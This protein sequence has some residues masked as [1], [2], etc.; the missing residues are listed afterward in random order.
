MSTDQK[1]L[2][3]D[4]LKTVQYRS[5]WARLGPEVSGTTNKFLA[6]LID[7]PCLEHFRSMPSRLFDEHFH[8]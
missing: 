2:T 8:K 7:S 3:Y 4:S 5:T 1:T 6:L